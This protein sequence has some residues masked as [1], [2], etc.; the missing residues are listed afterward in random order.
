MLWTPFSPFLTSGHQIISCIWAWFIYSLSEMPAELFMS[1][2]WLKSASCTPGCHP[3]SCCSWVKRENEIWLQVITLRIKMLHHTWFWG[4]TGHLL[5]LIISSRTNMITNF[6][7]IGWRQAD[8]WYLKKKKKKKLLKSFLRGKR[9]SSL[10]LM[11]LLWFYFHLI[12]SDILPNL[13]SI[14]S[15]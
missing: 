4:L 7:K 12:L 3:N 10:L 9:N 14:P 5:K 2:M 1:S 13:N 6:P 8:N 11:L 15:H